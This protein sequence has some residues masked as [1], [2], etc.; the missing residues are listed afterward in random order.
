MKK[1]VIGTLDIETSPYLA[2]VW[3]MWDQNIGVEQIVEERTVVSFCWKPLGGKPVYMDTGGKGKSHVRNDYWLLVALSKILDDADI[4]IAQNG[5]AF[6]LKVVNARL[7]MHN[8]KPYSPIRIIDTRNAAKEV[9]AFPHNKLAWLS[10]HLTDSPKDDHRK[11]PGMELWAECLKD[12]PLAWA[13]MKKYNIQDVVATEK[14]YLR[15]RPWIANHP[16]LGV[17]MQKQCCPACGSERVHKRGE[18]VSQ[19]SAYVRFHCQDCGK[20]S[21]GKSMLTKLAVRK[22]LLR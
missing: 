19:A 2:F 5:K 8:L 14:L 1:P 16:N 15:L 4:V 6:D 17:Y 21:Q 7:M 13:E 18:Q 11:F 22:V 12:N 9:A 10:K 3:N 20:W